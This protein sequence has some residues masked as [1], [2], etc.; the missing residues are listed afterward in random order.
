MTIQI[1]L[2]WTT[3]HPTL[4]PCCLELLCSD[5]IV[6]YDD[7]AFC[8]LCVL[9][10]SDD[11]RDECLRFFSHALSPNHWAAYRGLHFFAPSRRPKV[12]LQLVRRN[13]PDD[14]L[15]D[16]DSDFATLTEDDNPVAGGSPV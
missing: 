2:S 6:F 3:K 15:I 11:V 14:W 10:H 16:P 1:E 9:P 8:P 7:V 13:S 12:P 5:N 4:C